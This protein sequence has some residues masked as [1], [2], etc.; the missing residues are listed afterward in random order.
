M[1]IWWMLACPP[2][3]P[4]KTWAWK[5]PWRSRAQALQLIPPWPS[6]VQLQ[7]GG[8][9]TLRHAPN[10]T[11][12]PPFNNQKVLLNPLSDCGTY[13]RPL[14]LSN[15]LKSQFLPQNPSLSMVFFSEAFSNKKPKVI[16]LLSPATSQW[17]LDLPPSRSTRSIDLAFAAQRAFCLGFL[18]SF[19]RLGTWT[20]DAGGEG[21]PP[22]GG[23]GGRKILVEKQNILVRDVFWWLMSFKLA[24][25]KFQETMTIPCKQLRACW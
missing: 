7:V 20:E 14:V 24:N 19:G 16:H 15:Q 1:A 17:L 21:S 6:R 22:A 11:P 4:R 23:D 8:C 13:V 10:D 3:L 9:P 18:W 5:M 25:F 2:P 12:K